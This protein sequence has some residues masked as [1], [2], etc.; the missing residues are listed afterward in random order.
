MHFFTSFEKNQEKICLE[1]FSSGNF[2]QHQGQPKKSIGG[3]EDLKAQSFYA[4]F[5]S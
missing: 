3:R 2:Q 5:R 4:T 1:F